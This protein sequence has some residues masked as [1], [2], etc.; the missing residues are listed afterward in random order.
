MQTGIQMS[1]MTTSAD[2]TEGELKSLTEVA[3]GLMSRNIPK[4][5]R[6]R[7]VELRLITDQ[8]GILIPTPE[9]RIVCGRLG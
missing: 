4:A 6:E 7:L 3:G 9:G 1:R 5:H 8:M 2:L